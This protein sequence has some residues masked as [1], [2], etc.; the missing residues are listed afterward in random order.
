MHEITDLVE[1]QS[2]ALDGYMRNTDIRLKALEAKGWV[3]P[4][5]E[6]KI[7][8]ANQEIGEISQQLIAIEKK[9]GRPRGVGSMEF[10]DHS[11]RKSFSKFLKSGVIDENFSTKAFSSEFGQEGGYAVPEELDASLQN[12]LHSASAMRQLATVVS[13]YSADYKVAV[14]TGGLAAGWVG[15]K[16]GR[17]ETGTPE[18]AQIS[19]PSGELYA[20]PAATQWMLDD[21][22]FDI[23]AWLM[24]EIEGK[25]A[26]M[27][28]EAFI[29]GTGD[30]QP[31]GFLSYES[32]AEADAVRDFS[33]LKHKETAGSSITI[34]E[35]IDLTID[36]RGPYRRNGSWLMNSATAGL[37]R[38][39]VDD[40]G[41]YVWQ[42]S[43]IAGQPTMLNGF[44]VYFDE[45]MPDVASGSVP[46]AFGDFKAG[47]RIVDRTPLRVLRDNLTNKPYV[48]FYSTKRI[49]GMIVDSC[50]IR[51]LKMKA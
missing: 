11:Q 27:E 22:G 29:S 31:K 21:A 5:V 51:L 50:A 37:I 43:L 45:S 28:G 1:R 38:K 2:K 15:E 49:S 41:Q 46:I 12:Y 10:H 20:N 35:L 9:I 24:R 6:V 17:S 44:P 23:E 30:K 13:S 48:H 7:D 40:V 14:N 39:V 16:D 8:K 19:A 33:K 47:Y 36:L 18:I 3:D 42:P 34:E 26:A 32:S 4:L 25:F